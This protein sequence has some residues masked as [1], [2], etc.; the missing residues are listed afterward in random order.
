MS[1]WTY[2]GTLTGLITTPAFVIIL[3]SI[4]TEWLVRLFH[5]G[6][7]GNECKWSNYSGLL[8]SW[9]NFGTKYLAN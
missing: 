7:I 3:G 1:L 2:Y 6:P 5:S 9:G 8:N 4:K